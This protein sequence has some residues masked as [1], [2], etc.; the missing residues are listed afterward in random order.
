MKLWWSLGGETHFT[1]L[2]LES[3]CFNGLTV[4]LLNSRIVYGDGKASVTSSG[5]V[6]EEV[7]FRRFVEGT[8]TPWPTKEDFPP[9]LWTIY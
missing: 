4:P 3:S 6:V 5:F 7:P 8:K 2:L 1:E 9:L